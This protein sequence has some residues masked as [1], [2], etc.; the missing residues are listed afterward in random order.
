M[1]WKKSLSE[2][3]NMDSESKIVAADSTTEDQASV[4]HQWSEESIRLLVSATIA[5]AGDENSACRHVLVA[6]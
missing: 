1:P 6:G 5:L 4:A 3:L 2:S